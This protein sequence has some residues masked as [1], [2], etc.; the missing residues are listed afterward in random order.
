MAQATKQQLSST[1][2]QTL[3]KVN[4]MAKIY[5]AGQ[6]CFQISVSNSKDHSA[7]IVIDPF[8]EDFTG[9]KLPNLSADIALVSHNHKDH[10]NRNNRIENLCFLCP[11][12]HSQTETFCKPQTR[13]VDLEQIKESSSLHVGMRNQ[14]LQPSGRQYNRIK[15]MLR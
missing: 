15:N 7:D 10:N 2:S 12:C 6:S 9:L 4:N 5:W 3:K 14:G 11:N 13:E 1:S 8:D